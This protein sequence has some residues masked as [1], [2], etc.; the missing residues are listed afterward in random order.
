MEDLKKKVAELQE[1]LATANEKST[2]LE[3][4][5]TE[6]NEKVAEQ[7]ETITQLETKA[8][9]QEAVIVELNKKVSEQDKAVKADFPVIK[10]GKESYQIVIPKF[11]YDGKVYTAADLKNEPELAKTLLEEK[12]GV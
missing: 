2:A 3:A 8:T 6:L 11:R 4:T 9:E 5:I 7:D 12:S 10:I 1:Q